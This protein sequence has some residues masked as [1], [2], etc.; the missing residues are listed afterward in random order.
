MKYPSI[1]KLSF[2]LLTIICLLSIGTSGQCLRCPADANDAAIGATGPS[3]LTLRNGV[4]VNVGGG[5]IGACESL[6]IHASVA[7]N[8]FGISGG[9]GAGFTGGNGQIILPNGT[10]VD[11]TPD[12]METTFVAP[13]PCGTTV[14]K[15]M[16]SLNYT[17][18]PADI[19]AGGA[20][21]TFEYNDGRFLL[22]NPGNNCNV[23][24]SFSL[25]QS[26]S[27]A[28]L[29]IC[30]VSPSTNSVG[31]GSSTTFTVSGEGT[32]PL[33]YSWLGPNGF[34]S[35]NQTIVITNAQTRNAGIYT[36][37]IRDQ[38]GCVSTCS[39]TLL[40]TP[41]IS[42]VNL[43]GN[44]LIISGSGGTSNAVYIVMTSS[45]LTIPS[46]LWSPFLTNNFDVNGQF[47]F[48]HTID[49]SAAQR[50]FALKAQ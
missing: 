16:N 50:F 2:P 29:P 31:G 22:P 40:V 46:A 45:D 47:S 14:V 34:A 18:T 36:A 5:T 25:Q 19:A 28:S 48:T 6:I 3:A 32:G 9:V 20:V 35:T 15:E 17:L 26:V 11:V 27:I 4:D 43:A 12:D 38:F 37:I 49:P 8:P 24:L 41:R 39:G 10:A 23:K 44:D 21:F 1:A 30:S 7:Y 33:A 42:N 13:P